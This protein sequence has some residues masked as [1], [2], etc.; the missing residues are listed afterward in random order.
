MDIQELRYFTTDFI[1]L[2][3]LAVRKTEK[4]SKKGNL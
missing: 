3:V 4:W 1:R 2:T